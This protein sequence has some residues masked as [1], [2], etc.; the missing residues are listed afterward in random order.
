MG[1]LSGRT[2]LIVGGSAGIGLATAREFLAAG[3]RVAIVGRRQEPLAAARNALGAD[4]LAIAADAGDDAAAARVVDDVLRRWGRLDILINNAAVNPQDG[5]LIDM[6]LDDFDAVMR[7]NLRA[8][9]VWSQCAWRAAM[10]EHGGVILNM[11]S[12]G[13]LMLYPDIGA[14]SAS[15]AALI[16]LTRVLAAELG[17]GVRVNALAPGLV[18]TGMSASAWEGG[19]GERFAARL[20]LQR[21]GEPVDV[22]RSA[23]FL[24]SDAAA[25]ITGETLTIDGGTAVQAGR[26]RS[27]QPGGDGSGK[28][29]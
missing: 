14:Y 13:G 5:A 10:K 8:P 19:R 3:A 6:P 20:P 21:L 2:A 17:P 23:L 9:L 4:V 16:H 24:A 25:W 18:R 29:R 28:A 27:R 1:D 12:L 15:K 22:A 7:L 26:G 11:A